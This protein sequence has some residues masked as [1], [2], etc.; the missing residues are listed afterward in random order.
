MERQRYQGLALL[1][2]RLIGRQG[3]LE[4]RYIAVHT[5]LVLIEI[6]VKRQQVRRGTALPLALTWVCPIGLLHPINRNPGIDRDCPPCC[7]TRPAFNSFHIMMQQIVY[8]RREADKSGQC[9][10]AYLNRV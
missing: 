4:H 7:S 3:R 6:L 10:W 1:A 2:G 5:G 9:V 8:C